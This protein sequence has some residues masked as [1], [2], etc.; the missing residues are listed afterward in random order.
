MRRE[1]RAWAFNS[2]AHFVFENG[3]LAFFAFGSAALCD[4]RKRKSRMRCNAKTQSHEAPRGSRRHVICCLVSD[5]RQFRHSF[6]PPLY[7]PP[8][9]KSFHYS[10][11]REDKAEGSEKSKLGRGSGIQIWADLRFLLEER[12]RPTL[13]WTRTCFRLGLGSPR[14]M[15]GLASMNDT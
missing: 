15:I 10:W 2:N 1:L 5:Q 8:R 4:L 6:R 13:N 7:L 9:N 11:G 12:S 3:S 14:C